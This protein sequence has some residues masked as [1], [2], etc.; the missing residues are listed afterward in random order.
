MGYPEEVQGGVVRAQGWTAHLEDALTGRVALGQGGGEGL[1]V[2][3]G[4]RTRR[5]VVR[6]VERGVSAV[7]H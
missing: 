2:A 3:L 6:S 4:R 5:L 1:A 7:G